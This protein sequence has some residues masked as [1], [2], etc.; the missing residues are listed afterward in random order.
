LPATVSNGQ[1]LALTGPALCRI[2]RGNITRWNDAAIAATNPDMLLTNTPIVVMLLSTSAAIQ[3]AFTT[4]CG[5][6]R[7]SREARRMKQWALISVGG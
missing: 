6:V 2:F 1:T 5:K 3:L 4:Y 7:W